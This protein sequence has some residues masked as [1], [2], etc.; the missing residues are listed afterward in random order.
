V[1]TT[2]MKDASCCDT[3]VDSVPTKPLITTMEAG[4]KL[5]GCAKP[6]NSCV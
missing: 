4:S 3:T 6:V 2:C 1:Y 5:I